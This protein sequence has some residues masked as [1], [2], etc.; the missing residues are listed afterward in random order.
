[1]SKEKT[2]IKN[3]AIVTVGKVATQLI[4]FFLLP[5]YTAYL[6]TSEYGIVDLV[7]TLTSLIIPFITFQLD[8]GIFRYL[9]DVKNNEKEKKEFI[10]TTI[11]FLILQSIMYISIFIIVAHFVNNDYK[12]FLL[13]F[14]LIN[15]F[16]NILLQITRGLGDNVRY[17]VGSFIFATAGIIL[18]VI[19]IAGLKLG[20][21]GMLTATMIG[22][23]LCIIYLIIS[24][25]IYKYFSI[26]HYKKEKLNLLLKYSFPLIPNAISWWIV[27]ASDRLIVST[28]LNIEANGIYSVANKFSA[29]ITTMFGVFNITWTES[30]AVNYKEKDRDEFFNKIYDATFRIFGSICLGVIAIMPFAFKFMVNKQYND[31]YYQIPILI[32]GTF[33]HILVSFLGSIYVAKKLTKEIAKTSIFAA[34]INIVTN[35]IMIKFIGLYAAS[36]STLLAWI[37]M[38][39]YRYLDSKKYVK[40]TTDKPLVISLIVITII[41]ICTYYIRNYVIC[42]I[43]AS[44]VIL[45]VIILN[46]NTVK[47]IISII[48]NKFN[49]KI[50]E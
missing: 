43:I 36:I 25:K 1:M 48:K 27:N 50:S 17:T 41:T 12:Y 32:V 11:L 18:N 31:A 29:V 13:G 37:S 39:L 7:N 20:A 33:F 5:L 6:T 8:Q 44:I 3:T 14:L 28:I 42:G 47:F 16:T 38:Y 45:Y 22:H 4:S 46:R 23:L 34:I 19:L 35:L 21:Y 9:I 15:S 2:L 49:I 26:K 40:L 24:K 30:A 10:S